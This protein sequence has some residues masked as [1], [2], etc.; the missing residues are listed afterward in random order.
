MGDRQELRQLRRA[1]RIGI[2]GSRGGG[3][4]LGLRRFNVPDSFRV[5]GGKGT[6]TLHKSDRR[7]T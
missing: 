5:P 2:S 7:L 3:A 6:H 1:R 4:M